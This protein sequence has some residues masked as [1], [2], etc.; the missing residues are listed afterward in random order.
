MIRD[1][2]LLCVAVLIV[3]CFDPGE[4]EDTESSTG[5]GTDTPTTT[6]TPDDDGG[7]GGTMSTTAP[8]TGD[9]T[10]DDTGTPDPTTGGPDP[11]TGDSTGEPAGPETACAGRWQP[12]FQSTFPYPDG[13]IVGTAD[14]P[15]S[16]WGTV[17]GSASV[18]GERLVTIGDSTLVSSHGGELPV[19]GLRLRWSVLFGDPDNSAAIGF[20]ADVSGG[21]GLGTSLRASDGELALLESGADLEAQVLGQLR[22]G[23]EYFLELEIWGDTAT[24]W[25]STGNYATIPGAGLMATIEGV[26]VREATAGRWVSAHLTD[27]GSGSP[28][29]DDIEVAR[30]DVAPPEYEVVFADTFNRPNNPTVGNAE[31]PNTSVWNEHTAEADIQSNRLRMR[32]GYNTGIRA[33]A[34]DAVGVDQV[35]LR[36]VVSWAQTTNFGWPSVG[37]GV[38]GAPMSDPRIGFTLWNDGSDGHIIVAGYGGGIETAFANQAFAANTDY[39]VEVAV[40]GNY[41]VVTVRT[42]SF[43]GPVYAATGD[44]DIVAPP[45]TNDDVTIQN[46]GGVDSTIYFDEVQL[47]RYPGP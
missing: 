26:P 32:E 13:G 28:A 18:D 37:W 12:W 40:E 6:A 34:A 44:D 8:A 29:V 7:P 19:D 31:L 27:S 47:A 30:C 5:S 21:G 38:N 46:V 43:S 1:R 9:E 23:T 42:G 15:S 14:F 4:V 36:A 39:Y 2:F 33:P 41:G 25:L 10:A 11:D 45:A 3:G 16:P 20:N 24:L 35:R 22:V 17:E